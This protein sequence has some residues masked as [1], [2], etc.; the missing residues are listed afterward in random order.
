[1]TKPITFG[2]C[3][4][5]RIGVLHIDAF[6]TVRIMQAVKKQNPQFDWVQ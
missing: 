1:M 4:L 6:E 3:G 2:V 5:G